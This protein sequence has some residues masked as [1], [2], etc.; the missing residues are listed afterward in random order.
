MKIF[1]NPLI[2]FPGYSAMALFGR[3]WTRKESLNKVT[4]NHE[5]IHLKQEK[6]LLYVFYIPLY[7]LE[8]CFRFFQYKFKHHLAYRNVSL[9]REA[10]ENEIKETYLKTRKSYAFFGYFTEKKK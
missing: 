6:E 9:E 2:P 5:S 3:I 1:T 4:I 8:Y 7:V 10:Y